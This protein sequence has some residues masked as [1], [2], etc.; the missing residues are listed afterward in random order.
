M[1]DRYE[2]FQIAYSIIVENKPSK[3]LL[4]KNRLLFSTDDRIASEEIWY[5]RLKFIIFYYR[6]EDHLADLGWQFRPVFRQ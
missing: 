6:V 5:G 4:F 1:I 2:V 3:I